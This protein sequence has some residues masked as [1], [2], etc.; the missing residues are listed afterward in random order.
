MD[1]NNKNIVIFDGVCN[2]CNLSVK[3]LLKLDYKKSLFYSPMQGRTTKELGIYQEK[4]TEKEQS[5]LYKKSNSEIIYSRSDAIIEIL[6]D[7]YPFGFIFKL[8]KIIPHFLRDELYKYIAKNRY[9]IFGKK[10]QCMIPSE[11]I[12]ARFLP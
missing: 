8:F 9:K 4:L 3:I 11:D 1:I 2:L 7:L 10:E 6:N 12:K 5:I